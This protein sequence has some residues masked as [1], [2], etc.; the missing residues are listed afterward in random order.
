[1]NNFFKYNHS[2][3]SIPV[4]LTYRFNFL[5][6]QLSIFYKTTA[7]LHLFFGQAIVFGRIEYPV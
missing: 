6:A 2:L 4:F 3:Y 5:A 1:M 7:F